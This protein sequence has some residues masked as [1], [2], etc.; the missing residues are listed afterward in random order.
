MTLSWTPVTDR[1]FFTAVEPHR[2]NIG[3]IVGDDAAMLI[4]TGNTPEQ[5]AELLASAREKA[6]VPV[7]HVLLTHDHH[8]HIGG[9]PGLGEIVS[10][11]HENL[12]A[13]EATRTFSMAMAVDLGNQRVEFLHFGDAH[14]D[15]DV[16]VFLPGENVV[17]AG[18]LLE[19]GADPQ[20]DDRG[21]LSNWPM[22]LDGVLGAAN[23]R[24]QFV[25]GHG[26]AVDRE[27]AFI[28]RAE[29]GMLYSQTEMLIQQGV[30]LDDAASAV[31]WPFTAETLAAALPKAYAELKAKGIEP[32]RQLPIFGI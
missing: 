12:T 2:V 32:K 5:G 4:D 15:H 27:F 7:T 30:K 9:L 28:Q 6:G 31:D 14:T 23:A 3:L 19:E 16:L 25:P 8:D 18:D 1:V 10:I 26:A 17:F 22:V 29:V 11:A 20:I 13:V 24:T 21:S